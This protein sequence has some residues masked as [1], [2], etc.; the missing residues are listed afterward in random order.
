MNR[1]RSLRPNTVT[2]AGWLLADLL[3]GLAMLFF[4]LNTV[5]EAPEP[6]PT[7]TMTPSAT[8]TPTASV[9]PTLT[10]TKTITPTSTS[11]PSPTVYITKQPTVEA[12]AP[13]GLDLTP[14]LIYVSG[15]P[16]LI[17][18]QEDRTMESLRQQFAVSFDR[19]SNRRVGLVITLGYH[20][21][22]ESGYRIARI[23]NNMLREAYP[24]IFPSAVLKPF[25]F[26]SNDN[27]LPGTL[28]FEI[29]FFVEVNPP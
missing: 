22:S 24:D 10:P 28:S 9:T 26:T 27:L 18:K 5:G 19:Y 17:L 14:I 8:I 1:R 20:T 12:T 16:E 21:T 6:T 15:D 7:I 29:Y 13:V 11:S 25:W 4:V 2:L 23:A 3:L